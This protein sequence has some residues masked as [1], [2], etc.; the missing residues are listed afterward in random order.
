MVLRRSYLPE[1]SA[2]ILVIIIIIAVCF[3]IGVFVKTRLG[4]I[5]FK[6]L[7]NNIHRK[8]EGIVVILEAILKKM[9]PEN[10]DT[11]MELYQRTTNPNPVTENRK[12]DQ[13]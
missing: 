6:T 10:A 3:V 13:D 4:G 11:T 8:Q 5:I 9:D 7:E 2:D 1:I 12:E